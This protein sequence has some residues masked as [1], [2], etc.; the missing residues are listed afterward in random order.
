MH[1]IIRFDPNPQQLIFETLR[2]FVTAGDIIQTVRQ[3]F[4]IY[5]RKIMVHEA[6]RMMKDTDT[7]QNEKSYIV[8]CESP[9]QESFKNL[10]LVRYFLLSLIFCYREYTR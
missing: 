5:H 10:N 1:Y 8:T 6:G 2:Y 3:N 7:V 9:K 4:K